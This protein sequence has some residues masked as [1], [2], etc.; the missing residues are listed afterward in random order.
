MR[1]RPFKLLST[2]LFLLI[3]GVFITAFSLNRRNHTASILAIEVAFKKQ[4]DQQAQVTRDAV[5]KQAIEGRQEITLE[6]DLFVFRNRRLKPVCAT[7]LRETIPLQEAEQ[8]Y[9]QGL[10]LLPSSEAIPLFVS[11]AKRP[12][13]TPHD[14][15]LKICACI[16]LYELV[17]NQQIAWQMASLLNHMP[18][19]LPAAKQRFLNTQLAVQIPEWP[20]ITQRIDRLWAEAERITPLLPDLEL[21][22]H[23]AIGRQILSAQTNALALL[24][25]PDLKLAAPAQTTNALPQAL[26]TTLLPGL[27][28]Y[29]P[30]EAL[31]SAKHDID[32]QYRTG[33]LLLGLTSLLAVL[34]G[35]GIAIS[36]RKQRELDAMKTEFIATVSHEL[37]TPLSLIRLHAE[38]LHR[39]RIKPEKVEHYHQTILTETERLTGL[40]NNVLDFSR[41]QRKKLQIHPTKTE[42][43]A[44]CHQT[45]DSFQSRI[46]REQFELEKG[47]MPDLHAQVDPL[48]FSQ[49][50]FN[51]IDNSLKYSDELKL[52]RIDLEQTGR[53][54]YLRVSDQGIGIPDNMKKQIFNDF[55]RT[56]QQQ[57]TAR[58][59]SGIGLSVT[60]RLVEE[61]NGTIHVKD[62]H[63][64]GSIFTVTLKGT[65]ENTCS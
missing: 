56:N 64:R 35:G 63:P 16:N 34:L 15:Y 1:S 40:V 19:K 54:I 48:A 22:Y 59:G 9:L 45:I 61:M 27:W 62:N 37:R 2:G 13:E 20:E 11:A 7:Q 47:I 6:R 26:H 17:P 4:L 24:H 10:D 55:V 65:D 52:V 30:Q 38:T 42:L 14:L 49:I 31:K 5:N 44:L 25:R 39:K 51:L 36:N 46:Q 23:C 33:N 12:L 29:I 28:A 43:S 53:H 3:V 41:M 60:R 18:I 21:P 57:V 32:Q 8:A 58:R 50:L